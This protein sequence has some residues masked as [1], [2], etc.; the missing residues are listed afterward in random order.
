MTTPLDGLPVVFLDIDGVLNHHGVYDANAARRGQTR[1]VDWLDPSRVAL[2]NRLCERTGAV[3]VISSAWREYLGGWQAVQAV[4]VEAGFTGT[5]IGQTPDR[6]TRE[7]L[8]WLSGTRWDEI[9]YWLTWR[10][11]VTRWVVLDDCEVGEAC[12][13]ERFVRTSIN[14]GITAADVDRATAILQETP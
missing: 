7:G 13:R 2:L 9:E 1:P 11:D 10:P 5:V 3:V 4:L 14:T 12:P 6:V 8:L